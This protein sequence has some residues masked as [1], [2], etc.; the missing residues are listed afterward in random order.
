MLLQ[1]VS[2]HFPLARQRMLSSETITRPVVVYI[3]D[4]KCAV[5]VH[6]T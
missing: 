6:T 2:L 3:A 4:A 1:P 5:A